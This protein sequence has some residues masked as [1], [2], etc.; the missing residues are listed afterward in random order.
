[1]G[2]SRYYVHHCSFGGC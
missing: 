2:E 1:M